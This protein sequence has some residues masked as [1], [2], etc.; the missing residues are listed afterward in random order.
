VRT[1]EQIRGFGRDCI[2]GIGALHGDQNVIERLFAVEGRGL[3]KQLIVAGLNGDKDRV[4]GRSERSALPL[5]DTHDCKFHTVNR[6][7]LSNRR[8]RAKEIGCHLTAYHRYEGAGLVI[9]VRKKTAGCD[10]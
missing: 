3:S 2:H 7:D 1:A 5:Q 4:I 6:D 8:D 9:A 10:L